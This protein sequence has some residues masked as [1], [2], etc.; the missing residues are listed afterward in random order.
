[1]GEY[2]STLVLQQ[3]HQPSS[4]LL[5]HTHTC[6]RAKWNGEREKEKSNGEKQSKGHC[7]KR[8]SAPNSGT[9]TFT[10]WSATYKAVLFCSIRS[11][12]ETARDRERQRARQERD[13]QRERQRQTET[14]RECVYVCVSLSLTRSL[15][16]SLSLSRPLS[17]N[18]SHLPSPSS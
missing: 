7:K 18:L 15:D 17:L 5:T 10:V 8:N 11:K 9:K 12:Q 13:R 14:D 3:N 1:M 16:L 4:L 2:L 6:Q